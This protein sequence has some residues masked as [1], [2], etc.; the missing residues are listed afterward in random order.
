MMSVA[1][2]YSMRNPN[3]SDKDAG[4]DPRVTTENFRKEVWKPTLAF[5]TCSVGCMHAYVG[6]FPGLFVSSVRRIE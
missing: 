1:D 4:S 3:E 5:S 6:S 2:R